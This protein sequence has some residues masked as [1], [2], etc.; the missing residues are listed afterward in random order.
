[1]IG[2]LLLFQ[3][4]IPDSSALFAAADRFRVPHD[5]MLAVAWMETRDG[6]HIHKGPGREQ[7]DSLGCRRVCRELGRMQINPC[8]F[9]LP[10]T[11]SATNRLWGAMLLHRHFNRLHS[12]PAAIKAYNGSGPMSEWYQIQ[13]LAFIGRRKIE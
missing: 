1:M 2:L 6:L 3:L 4:A 12:W 8:I 11:T 5:V 7:C 9:H 10:D 13:A